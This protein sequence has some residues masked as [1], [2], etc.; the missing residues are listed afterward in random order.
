MIAS[1]PAIG[2]AGQMKKQKVTPKAASFKQA[3]TYKSIGDTQD[4]EKNSNRAQPGHILINLYQPPV[5]S[6]EEVIS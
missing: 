4:K 6:M 2:K 5:I 1:R 3:T